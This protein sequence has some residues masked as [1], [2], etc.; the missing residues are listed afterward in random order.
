MLQ[1]RIALAGIVLLGAAPAR[2]QAPGVE[3]PV[4][5]SVRPVAGTVARGTVVDVRVDAVIDGNWHLYS[6]TQPPGGPNATRF[7]LAPGS[8]FSLA[9]PVKQPMPEVEHDRNF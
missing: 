2:A 8:P 7:T 3:E 4:S 9:G 5:W 1:V 6:I